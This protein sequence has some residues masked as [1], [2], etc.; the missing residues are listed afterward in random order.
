[1]KV[2]KTASGKIN[3]TLTK[4]E[5]LNIGKKNSWLNTKVAKKEDGWPKDLKEGRFDEYCKKQGFEN[6][7]CIGCAKKAMESDDASVRGMATFYMNTVKPKG[8]DVGD[9]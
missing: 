7:A 8:K 9:I 2:I 3:L 5:W 1:M 6:G 4:K